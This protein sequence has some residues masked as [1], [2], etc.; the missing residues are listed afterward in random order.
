LNTKNRPA[1]GRISILAELGLRP[2][3]A[4]PVQKDIGL[5]A[6][7]S[8]DRFTLAARRTLDSLS[9]MVRQS[10]VAAETLTLAVAISLEPRAARGPNSRPAIATQV[11]QPDTEA[12]D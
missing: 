8:E 3:Q 11:S 5:L 1:V 10:P 9:G 4:E 2:I 7:T 6:M 12:P